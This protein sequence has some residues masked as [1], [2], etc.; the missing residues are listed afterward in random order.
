M[1][2][3]APRRSNVASCSAF[4]NTTENARTTSSSNRQHNSETRRTYCT[5]CTVH[6]EYTIVY[7]HV[8]WFN[9]YSSTRV[10][11]KLF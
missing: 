2:W 3:T 1:D 10:Y 5:L 8:D 11:V 4:G 7:N 9:F 6:L